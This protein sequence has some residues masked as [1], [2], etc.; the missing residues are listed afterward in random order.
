MK[1]MIF[2]ITL[3]CL[4]SWLMA[5]GF[6]YENQKSTG[7]PAGWEELASRK[8]SKER[9]E[10]KNVLLYLPI[11]QITFAAAEAFYVP[12]IYQ[13]K[14][15]NFLSL[16]TRLGGGYSYKS[17]AGSINF[18]PGIKI[19][20]IG[21]GLDTAAG[22]FIGIEFLTE[23]EITSY[24]ADTYRFALSNLGMA[25][26]VGYQLVIKNGFTLMGSGGVAARYSLENSN[27]L[28]YNIAP[29][30]DDGNDWGT[31]IHPDFVFALGY[32]W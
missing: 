15:S 4:S 27:N 22:L 29:A 12:F 24:A 1:R 16:Q 25:Y 11:H 13:R 26:N 14:L 2:I 7:R 17:D 23:F 19:T 21:R 20:P 10:R 6:L 30:A 9:K 31:V 18:R 3:L 8:N 28:I 32:A 5:E